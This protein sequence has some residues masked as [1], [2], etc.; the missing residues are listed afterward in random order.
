MK[1]VLVANRGEIALR[2][3]R[4]CRAEGLAT[5]AVYSDADQSLPHVWAADKS[6]KIGPPAASLSYLQ[7]E[8]L[9]HVA[10]ETGCDAL[11]PG[12]GFLAERAEF[13][14]R[15]AEEGILFIGPTAEV[16]ALMG[17]KSAARRTVTGLKIPVVPGSSDAFVNETEAARAVDAIGFPLL[18]KARAGGGGRGI[19]LVEEKRDFAARF[20]EARGEAQA[21]FGDG[22]LYMERYFAQVRH[23]EVQVF[24]DSHGNVGHAWERDC[25][26]QRRHQKLIEEAPASILDDATR[27]AI[28]AAAV[29]V[30]A[31]VNYQGAGTVEF[32]F[33]AES[34]DFYFL[35][36]NTRIQVEHP[37][38]EVV[39]GIDLV[40]EQLRTSAGE[41]LS[42]ARQPPE[43]KGH[44]VEFR[45]NAEDPE[46]S[47]RPVPGTI[48]R[49]D[50]PRGPRLRLDSH[51]YQGYTVPPY[52][53][54]ML[55]K[56][57]VGGD[58]RDMAL[59]TA[60][61]ALASFR[62]EG[63]PTT[64]ALHRR[65]LGHD[66]FIHNRIDTRWVESLTN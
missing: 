6:V 47:F 31:G 28:C 44:A 8:L 56:L 22:H 53:D 50:P 38:T 24:G 18:L 46:Q 4:A 54:S 16:I 14:R 30:A 37:V 7:P 52:Y 65:I 9:L 19:R 55:G 40:R 23:I 61:A 11:H 57:I 29:K 58:T 63:I 45:I 3:I 1:R 60:S 33:D 13:A 32:L 43:I 59:A 25:S 2:I 15:C 62:V 39:T 26:V 36:M 42:F 48:R 35:E 12:Y 41:T 64:I 20:A 21:A 51:V 5:V 10:R 34:G 49:W 27:R 17:D 66:D